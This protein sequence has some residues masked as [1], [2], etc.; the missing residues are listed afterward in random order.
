MTAMWISELSRRSGVP[1]PTIKYYLR[2]ELLRP[3]TATGATRASYDDSHVRRLRLVRALVV[4]GGMGLDRVR[5]VLAAVDDTDAD[6]H[7]VLAAAHQELS[8]EPDEAPSEEARRQVEALLRRRRWKVH[9]GGRHSAALAAALDG[10]AAA[11]QPLDDRA[12]ATYAEGAGLVAKGEIDTLS[13]ADREDAATY[14][15]TGTV[16]AEP[17]LLALRRMAHQHY[18]GQRFAGPEPS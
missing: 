7:E 4:V 17:V 13:V 16:L 2:E 5:A 9:P 10:L 3:G 1:V 6:L 18:S 11:G 14:A 12:L 15:V 8:P